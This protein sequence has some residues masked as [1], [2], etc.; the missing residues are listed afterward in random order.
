MSSWW[1][2]P[3]IAVSAPDAARQLAPQ[4]TSV[5]SI[6]RVSLHARDLLSKSYERRKPGCISSFGIGIR[7]RLTTKPAIDSLGKIDFR[8]AMTEATAP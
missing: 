2:E 3:G 8:S 4:P 1:K 6:L 5:G 7:G